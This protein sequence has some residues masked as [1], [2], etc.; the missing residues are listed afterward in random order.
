[1]GWVGGG[2]PSPW[3][4]GISGGYLS[5]TLDSVIDNFPKNKRRKENPG[6]DC[7][8]LPVS[9]LSF[10]V[11]CKNSS[12][13]SSQCQDPFKPHGAFNTEW[14]GAARMASVKNKTAASTFYSV[15]L[16]LPTNYGRQ[17]TY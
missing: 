1:M 6:R 12:S 11:R 9:P 15:N 8:F 16:S 17:S 7:L 3:I 14:S 5:Q 10:V 13:A 4:P 2:F